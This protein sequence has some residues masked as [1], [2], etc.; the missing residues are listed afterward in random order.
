LADAKKSQRV[1]TAARCLLFAA[2]GTDE[3]ARLRHREAMRSVF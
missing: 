2:D 1:V 3:D